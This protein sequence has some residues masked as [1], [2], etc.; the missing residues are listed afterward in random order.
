MTKTTLTKNIALVMISSCLSYGVHSQ[1]NLKGAKE[2]LNEKTT[3]VTTK[4]ENPSS[5]VGPPAYDPESPIY[6]A[7]STTRDEISSTKS[8]LKD[9]NWLKN[10]EGSNENATRYLAKAKENLAKLQ[11]DPIESKKGYVKDLAADWDAVDALRQSKYESF[12]ADEAYDSKLDAYHRFA[13]N[14]WE[15]QDKSLEPSY[16]GYAAFRK[17]F[18]SARVEKF[19][20]SYVQKRVEQIDNYFKVVVYDIVP[21]LDAKANK[22]IKE[23]HGKNSSGDEDYLLN[24][25]HYQKD[26]EEINEII[27]YNKKYLLEDKSGIDAVSAKIDKE[28]S[29]LDEYISSGKLDAR[30]ARFAQA[31]I[32]AVRLAPS[33]MSN[34]KYESMAKTGVDK[35]TVNRVT[36]T[37]DVWIVK[38]NDWGLP[39]YKYLT[40]DLA[41]TKEGKCYLA[42]GQIR[43][44]YE[45]GGVYGGEHFNYW[46]AQEEMNCGN[47]NK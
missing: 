2:K 16:Q 43:K 31:M 5:V 22:V 44:T 47:I 28:K 33:K 36:I 25:K 30:R 34:P 35:G 8:V 26:F 18:E 11:A 9:E 4:S 6:R 45:G 37:N 38:K 15:I 29:I 1:I 17:D 39:L 32:D 46:G 21:E 7:Y 41:V 27:A 23:L 14:G 42:Y 40:V 20:T 3:T 12:K 10:V 19:K 13:M 24:A